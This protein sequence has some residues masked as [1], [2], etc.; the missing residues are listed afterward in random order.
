M[1]NLHQLRNGYTDE[2]LPMYLLLGMVA[3][4]ER[5]VELI[6]KCDLSRQA[7]VVGELEAGSDEMDEVLAAVLG[8]IALR[9]KTRELKSFASHTRND[10]EV[11]AQQPIALRDLLR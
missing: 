6:E 7:E 11:A 2:H 9:N 10:T 8:L 1:S 5:A 3:G 4:L